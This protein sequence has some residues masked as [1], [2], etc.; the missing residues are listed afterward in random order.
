MKI[1]LATAFGAAIL[2]AIGTAC[3]ANAPIVSGGQGAEG[4][5]WA[6]ILFA[7]VVFGFLMR[8]LSQLGSEGMEGDDEPG[9]CEPTRLRH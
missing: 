8:A 5:A 6:P 1:F 3:A 7:I 4:A 2:L 9:K